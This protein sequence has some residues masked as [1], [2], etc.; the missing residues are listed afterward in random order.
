MIITVSMN[1]AI[2]KTADVPDFILGGVNKLRNCIIDA[3]GKGVNVSKTLRVLN[4]PNMAC[5]FVGG[6]TGEAIKTSLQRQMIMSDFV[7]VEGETRCNL[8]VNTVFGMTEM[9]EPGPKISQ[10]ELNQLIAKLQHHAKPGTLFVLS[11][12]VPEGVPDDIYMQLTEML[13]KSGC[14][15]FL[16]AG[17]ELLKKGIEAHPDYMKPNFKEIKELYGFDGDFATKDE[18]IAWVK[19]KAN[20]LYSKGAKFVAISLGGDGAIFTDGVE[21]IHVPAKNIDVISP[22]GAGDA[23]TAA[24]AYGIDSNMHFRD[25]IR[26]AMAVSGG[27]CMSPGTKPPTKEDIVKLLRQA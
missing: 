17:G 27:A 12:S 19:E 20:D 14:K 22:V 23:M 6:A 25:I 24:I 13:H 1:P 3:G 11:G 8:K 10:A 18:M 26:Y 7:T 2:D 5:G 4:K 16:D 15:V 9:D 21:T